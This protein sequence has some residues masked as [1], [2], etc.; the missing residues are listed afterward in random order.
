MSCHFQNFPA[1]NSFGRSF[2]AKGYTM[3]GTQTMIEG[4]DLSLPSTLNASIITKLR[5]QVKG[6]DDD[7]RGEVQW[8]DEAAFLVGGRAADKVGFL[9]EL[10]LG[11]GAADTGDGS[12]SC[13]D[14]NGNPGH[15]LTL[16]CLTVLQIPVQVIH[17]APSCPPSFISASEKVL[18]SSLF[19]PMDWALVMA[20]KC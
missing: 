13:T 6:D 15:P 5:Y 9:M 14:A 19:Q 16:T 20:L 17:T 1:L 11:G 4:E 3:Q 8:P 12:L 2:R 18:A 10:G 7:N